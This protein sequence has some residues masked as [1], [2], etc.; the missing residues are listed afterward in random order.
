[1]AI[2]RS[3]TFRVRC[4][5]FDVLLGL[6][7]F[8]GVAGTGSAQPVIAQQPQSQTNVMAHLHVILPPTLQFAASTYTV[9]ESAGAVTL[10]VQRLNDTNTVMSADYATADGTAT[11]GLKYTAV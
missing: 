9:A 3:P 6:L 11:H 8:P 10:T 4:S 1:V 7:L 2:T 5:T